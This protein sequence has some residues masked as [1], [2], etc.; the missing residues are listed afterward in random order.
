MQAIMY[1]VIEVQGSAHGWNWGG[2]TPSLSS[3]V[4]GATGAW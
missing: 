4:L 2:L 1:K 3:G